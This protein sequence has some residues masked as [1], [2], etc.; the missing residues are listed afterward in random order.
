M[1]FSHY[2]DS[3]VLHLLGWHITSPSQPSPLSLTALCP[4]RFALAF[5]HSLRRF[6]PTRFSFCSFDAPTKPI[7]TGLLLSYKT[8]RNALRS[9]TLRALLFVHVESMRA[10]RKKH[11]IPFF[12]PFSCLP[13]ISQLEEIERSAS[14]SHQ[15]QKLARPCVSFWSQLRSPTGHSSVS[16]P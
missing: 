13:L 15:R 1:H 16:H 10:M 7:F 11:T 6:T 9:K 12:C 8:L 14:F 2:A 3:G 5:F 4:L